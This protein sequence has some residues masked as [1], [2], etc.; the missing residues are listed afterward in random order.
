MHELVI[1]GVL[2]LLFTGCIWWNWETVKLNSSS[3]H[4]QWLFWI[5]II[6]P[7]ISCIYFGVIVW[8]E[9][10]ID[11]SQNGYNNFLDISKLPLYLLA[12]SPIFGA[13]VASAHRSLQTDIQIKKTQRQIEITEVKNDLD[14]HIAKRKFINEQLFDVIGKNK[15]KIISPNSLF[16]HFFQEENTQIHLKKIELGNI[17]DALSNFKEKLED[18][19]EDQGL[20]EIFGTHKIIQYSSPL[21]K[22]RYLDLAIFRLKDLFY[23]EIEGRPKDK[24]IESLFEKIIKMRDEKVEL[25]ASDLDNFYLTYYAWIFFEA[26]NLVALINNI[27]GILSFI[28]RIDD[29]ENKLNNLNE[30]INKVNLRYIELDY[31]FQIA[32]N[33]SA[34]LTPNK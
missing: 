20:R 7:I 15:E 19:L 22:A 12:S 33:L 30:Y 8:S 21:I 32:Y 23:L 6:F 3:L 5:V 29:I 28:Q 31:N 9:Y 14:M 16:L 18:L 24:H 11:I 10:P 13:F 4:Q 17:K 25:T 26:K 27:I 34:D 2:V 1:Y